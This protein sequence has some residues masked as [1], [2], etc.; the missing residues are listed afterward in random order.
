M[1]N[2]QKVVIVGGGTA[3][4]MAAAGLAKT[5]GRELD[6][7]LI[8]SDAIGTVGVGEATIPPIKNFN[9]LLELD[10]AEF[11]REVN[12]TFKLGIE[13]ENWGDLGESYFHPFAPHGVDTWAAQFH[14]YWLRAKRLGQGGAFDDFSLEACMAGA[15]R[16][17]N[18]SGRPA[19]YAYH[20]DATGYAR[21]LRR[22]SEGLGVTRSEGKVVDVA[23][24]PESGFIESVTLDC[25]RTIAGDLF[26][27]CSGFRALL[28]EQTLGTGWEDWSHWLR[29]DRAI[30]VQTESLGAAV[31]YTRA[32][33]RSCGW[34]W[35]IPLQHRVGN[36]LVYCSDY[37]D[38]DSAAKLLLDNLDGRT[39]AEPRPIRFKTGRRLQQW[40][41]NCVS[42]GLASGFLE[43]LESTSIHLIQNS[44][45]RLIKMFPRRGFEPTVVDQ[46]NREVRQEIEYIRDFIILHYHVTRRVDS[47]YWTDC[48]EMT[49]PD[50][51][52]HRIELFSQNGLVFR[53]NNEL[54]SEVSW[55]SVMLGQG[56]DPQ[57]YHPV[58]DSLDESKLKAMMSGVKADIDR[59]VRDAPSHE[60]YLGRF[61]Q[62]A[63]G[64]G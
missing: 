37:M 55:T 32:T 8:E 49:V 45:I 10:E 59:V 31:P 38:E 44:M 33:A 51:L 53:E 63:A 2:L 40:N 25:G 43:P 7:E 11:L 27:D 6:I 28:I 9:L 48:R 56:I 50:S 4:W 52:R 26:I 46:F 13:F 12:G 3:G 36:G 34:Q 42:L 24:H 20:F 47:P 58:V 5:F 29:S 35:K 60:Q 30:A 17:G 64:T 23:Q 21:L 54:F 62:P 16:F 22:I 61:R 19:N 14:H 39:L 15:R 57:A 41:R 1:N 18:N